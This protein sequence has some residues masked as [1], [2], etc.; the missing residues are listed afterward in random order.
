MSDRHEIDEHLLEVM[1]QLVGTSLAKKLLLEAGDSREVFEADVRR[2][3]DTCALNRRELVSDELQGPRFD[4]SR[5]QAAAILSRVHVRGLLCTLLR[6][7]SETALALGDD[8]A[9]FVGHAC[10]HFNKGEAALA[11]HI[12]APSTLVEDDADVDPNVLNHVAK[13]HSA[14]N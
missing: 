8:C 14:N 1:G 12:P 2:L 5:Q 11:E 13:A 4:G 3:L 9:D 7:A 6:C 10:G